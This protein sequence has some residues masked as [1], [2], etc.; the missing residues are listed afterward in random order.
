MKRL[1]R[2]LSADFSPGHRVRHSRRVRLF[3]LGKCAKAQMLLQARLGRALEALQGGRPSPLLVSISLPL[4]QAGRNVPSPWRSLLYCRFYVRGRECPESSKAPGSFGRLLHP[5]C[6][7]VSAADAAPPHSLWM[8]M[9][10]PAPACCCPSST[11]LPSFLRVCLR[12][13]G[14]ASGN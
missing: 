11:F 13:S 3:L 7:L 9:Y 6:S 10:L 5:C 1:C 4:P 2:P 8:A 12:D 14:S